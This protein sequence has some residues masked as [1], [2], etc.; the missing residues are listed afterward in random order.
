MCF[1]SSKG[2]NGHASAKPTASPGGKSDGTPGNSFQWPRIG[3]AHCERGGIL[4]QGLQ[5]RFQWPRIGQAHCEHTWEGSLRGADDFRFNGHASAKPTAS[6]SRS[7]CRVR[8]LSVSMATHRPSPLRVIPKDLKFMVITSISFNGHASAKPTARRYRRCSGPTLQPVSFNGHASAKP[9]A[10][11][12][13]PWCSSGGRSCI[14]FNGH[15]SAKP[16][17]RD[18]RRSPFLDRV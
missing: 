12:G 10:R 17:A 15:A 3:Q 2:F 18:P 5:P 7:P 9:T 8:S 11:R 1:S 13:S 16:T 14:G 6:L 4:G